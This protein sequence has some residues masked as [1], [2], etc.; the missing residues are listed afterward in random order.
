MEYT[1]YLNLGFYIAIVLFHITTIFFT[2]HVIYCSKFDKKST[3]LD[4]ISNSFFI[5]LASR[6]F[7]AILATP[8]HVYLT[9]Y[10]SAEVSL[11]YFLSD[12]ASHYGDGA[13]VQSGEASP[14][15]R[16]IDLGPSARLVRQQVQGFVVS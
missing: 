3:K 9:A 4:R 15:L 12:F 14:A 8:Y 13:V 16:S 5:F 10:W 7:G 11:I 6:G 1:K 2:F